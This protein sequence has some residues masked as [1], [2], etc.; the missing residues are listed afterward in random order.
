MTI[1]SF[2]STSQ[3]GAPEITLKYD[4]GSNLYTASVTDTN[5]VLAS[6]YT[7]TASGVTMSKSGNTLNI[8]APLSALANGSVLASATGRSLVPAI[9]LTDLDGQREADGGHGGGQRRAGKSL[10]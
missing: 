5:G 4:A 1:P 6:D 2:S 9:W 3:T 8:S 10:F 7:F